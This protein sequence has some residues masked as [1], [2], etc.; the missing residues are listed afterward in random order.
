L[1]ND[2]KSLGNNKSSASSLPHATIENADDPSS[3]V[4]KQWSDPLK[5][6]DRKRQVAKEIKRRDSQKSESGR[7]K[8]VVGK[9]Y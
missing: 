1:E 4:V 8:R 9:H 3:R 5:A 2:E 7:R 6:K